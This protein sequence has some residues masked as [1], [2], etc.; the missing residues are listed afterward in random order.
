MSHLVQ[1][2]LV[3]EV[4]INIDLDR[5]E[6]VVSDDLLLASLDANLNDSTDGR[7]PF[8]VETMKRGLAESL[9]TAMWQAVSADV[10]SRH[11]RMVSAG[12][13]SSTNVSHLLT[14]AKMRKVRYVCLGH[15]VKVL[16]LS[17]ARSDPDGT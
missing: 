10:G 14:E 17:T 13:R 6:E 16:E 12:E 7:Q 8:S 2:R 1:K 11:N 15:E 4:M 9:E 5:D 3:L